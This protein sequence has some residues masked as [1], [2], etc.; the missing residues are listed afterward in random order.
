MLCSHPM[1]LTCCRPF[2][3]WSPQLQP[4][5]LSSWCSGSVCVCVCVCVCVYV[6]THMY[7]LMLTVHSELEVAFGIFASSAER[8]LDIFW[9]VIF[10]NFSCCPYFFQWPLLLWRPRKFCMRG[11]TA[12]TRLEGDTGGTCL[13]AAFLQQLPFP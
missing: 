1:S 7:V 8:N 10:Q 3:F 9:Y 2:A 5:G 4:K 13:E 11:T 6:H 12:R